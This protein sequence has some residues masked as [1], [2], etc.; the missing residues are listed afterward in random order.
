MSS[1]S[2]QRAETSDKQAKSEQLTAA[3][4]PV[5]DRWLLATHFSLP[6]THFSLPA[7]HFSLPATRFSLPA[8]RFS[9]PACYSLLPDR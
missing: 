5:A 8:T 4:K 7:T 9:L 3:A 1:S 2:E 6:A